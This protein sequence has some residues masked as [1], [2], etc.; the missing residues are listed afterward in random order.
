[1]SKHYEINSM[2][3]Y[4]LR[5][6]QGYEKGDKRCDLKNLDTTNQQNKQIIFFR[7]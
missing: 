4:S 5:A 3:P 1:M 2:S 6:F 7:R